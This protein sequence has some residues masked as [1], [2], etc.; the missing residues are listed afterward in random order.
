MSGNLIFGMLFSVLVGLGGAIEKKGSAHMGLGAKWRDCYAQ[1]VHP[2]FLCFFKDQAAATSATTMPARGGAD[3]FFT[4]LDL[5]LVL[6]FITPVKKGENLQLDLEL[7]EEV[8][9]LRLK[10]AADQEKWKT[11]LMEWKDYAKDYG[12]RLYLTRVACG[13]V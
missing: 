1:V 10:S 2:G 13:G 9:K 5:R 4:P 8:I 3:T 11:L 12:D 7:S 6:N